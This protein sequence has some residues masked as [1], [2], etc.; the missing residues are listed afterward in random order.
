M[1]SLSQGEPEQ[2]DLGHGVDVGRRGVG[3][4]AHDGDRARAAERLALDRPRD[5]LWSDGDD[6]RLAR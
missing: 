2:R 1:G 6:R 3:V 4:A 5:P